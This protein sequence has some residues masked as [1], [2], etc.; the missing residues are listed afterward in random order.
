MR[1]FF[2]KK[3]LKN[4]HKYILMSLIFCLLSMCI[5][6]QTNIDTVII[7]GNKKTKNYI[8]EREILHPINSP[9]DSLVLKEDINRLY[10]LGIFSTV[11]IN[12]EN[13]IYYVNLVE[14]FSILPDLVIDYSEIEKE[15]SYGLGLAHINFLGLNQSLY[16]GGAFIGNQKW[17][18][19]SL[20]NPWVYGDHISL[21]TILYNRF[22]ENPFYD[23]SYNETYFLAESGFYRGLNNKFEFGLSFYKNKKHTIFDANMMP[24]NEQNHYRYVNI[25]F[26]YQYDTRD[27]YKDPL[28][29][30]LFEISTGY[31]KSLTD[32]SSD[33]AQLSIS[34]DKFFLLKSKY[35]HQPVISYSILGLFKIPNFSKLPVHEYEYLGGEDFVRG[36]SSFPDEYPDDFSK[37]IE[38]SS[39]LYSHLELQSTILRKRDYGNIEFGMDGVLFI[40]SG[41]GSKQF[42]NFSSDNLLVGYGFG[43]KFFIT[44]PP[45]I[46]LMFGFN[47][48][49]QSYTHFSN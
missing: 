3:M 15:W 24:E 44:G 36:Y 23:F 21:R 17:F 48:Y 33:I 11:D 41:I 46:S 49:G 19:L 8:I 4:M 30:S 47:P 43:F 25:D 2:L 37:N 27:I 28:K 18:A 31:Q 29:G 38:V 42:D 14:S 35:L 6:S 34:F 13:N 32:N 5:G 1:A 22:A 20:Y 16:F 7:S 45:P 10:N 12:I 9:L 39:I 26:N 40:N